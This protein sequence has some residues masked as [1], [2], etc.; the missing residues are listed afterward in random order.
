MN[1]KQVICVTAL[2]CAAVSA[3]SWLGC[4]RSSSSNSSALRDDSSMSKNNDPGW[5]YKS[6]ETVISPDPEQQI[7]QLKQQ[8]Q[9]FA[10]DGWLV[11]SSS[12]PLAQ[13]DGTM[14]RKYELKRARK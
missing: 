3:T 4:E 5:E 10:Q 1:T 14:N 9:G 6:V 12:K 11:L 8:M 2:V 13:P 7:G